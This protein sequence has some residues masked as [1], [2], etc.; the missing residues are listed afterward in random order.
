MAWTVL[1]A[2]HKVC[3]RDIQGIYDAYVFC[4]KAFLVQKSR[5]ESIGRLVDTIND[6]Y[7]FVHEMEPLKKVKSHKKIIVQIMQQATEC[8]Y[9]I[10]DY[11]NNKDYCKF[12]RIPK[13]RRF[14]NDVFFRETSDEESGICRRY[15]DRRIPF[16]IP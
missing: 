11:S 15:E 10:R 13:F 3:H 6:T 7:E 2:A 9:F 16:Q 8:G 12:F 1:S 4:V 14:R 5:D